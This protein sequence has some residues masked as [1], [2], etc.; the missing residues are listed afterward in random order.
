MNLILNNRD[1]NLKRKQTVLFVGLLF[2][3]LICVI[4]LYCSGVIGTDTRG[5]IQP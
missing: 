5:L 2:V 4:A 1:M 3:A